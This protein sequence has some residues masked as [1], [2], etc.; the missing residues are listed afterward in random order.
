MIDEFDVNNIATSHERSLIIARVA[1]D[2]ETLSD[3]TQIRW[4]PQIGGQIYFLQNPM[5][6]V[7]LEGNRG[8][9]KTE[10]LLADFCQHC[11]PVRPGHPL[12]GYGR[13]W[14]GI[15]FRKSYPDL[16]DV[17]EKSQRVIPVLFPGA[18]Y[19]QQAHVW[20]FPT[21][22]TLRFAFAENENDYWKY[23]G[24]EYPWIGWEELTT[25]ANDRLYLRMMSLCRSPMP[26]M[27]RKYRSTTNP[28]GP[29]HGWVKARWRLPMYRDGVIDDDVDEQGRI[30]LPRASVCVR[31]EDNAVLLRTEPDY[32]DKI[33][34]NADDPA[35]MAAWTEG[36]WTITSGGM[37]DDLFRYKIHVMP[38]F[39]PPPTWRIDRAYDDGSSAPFA[40]GWFAESDGSDVV[41]DGN[42]WPT[43]RGDLFLFKE[44]YGYNGKNGKNEGLKFTAS[45]ITAGIREREKDWKIA[46]RVLDGPADSAI[47]ARNH[48]VCIAD[49]M[50]QP[51]TLADGRLYPGLTWAEA[52]KRA[53][54]RVAGWKQIRALMKQS[55]PIAGRR[56]RPGFFVCRGCS[57]WLRTV[58]TLPRSEKNRDDVDA[59]EDHMGDMTRYRVHN[60][61][62]VIVSR[63]NT[64]F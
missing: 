3:G 59:P 10:V 48:G 5:F 16:M 28:Y 8:G 44:W 51:V 46:G 2:I 41:I 25:W 40:V 50:R 4:K 38:D 19:N 26:H 36:S 43:K 17:I 63:A 34:E 52:D 15:L 47:F 32:Q 35:M 23:H 9:G 11:G 61:P 7:L 13:Y 14:R 53:G 55:I 62:R 54:T 6:E 33:R 42:T 56:E 60:P 21:G 29:G 22:E 18:I 12:A 27:P 58:P 1:G 24:S 20:T 57:Q 39:I 30:R 31:L 64:G 37:F 45:E 49:D